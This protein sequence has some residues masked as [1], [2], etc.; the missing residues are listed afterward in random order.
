LKG[1]GIEGAEISFFFGNLN[2]WRK[3]FSLFL[4]L[5]RIEFCGVSRGV[6][7]ALFRDSFVL[8]KNPVRCEEGFIVSKDSG[9]RD[10][11]DLEDVFWR[12]FHKASYRKKSFLAR[13]P[14][15]RG[16]KKEKTPLYEK[17]VK[18]GDFFSKTSD[19]EDF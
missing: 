8:Q 10:V 11:L 4:D 9:I 17:E 19:S 12:V 3:T 15:Q 7:V 5:G 1:V 16:R 2:L 18:Y 13:F 6:D 14:C